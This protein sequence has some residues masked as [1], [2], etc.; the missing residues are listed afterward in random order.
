MKRLFF[1]C[2]LFL[3]G[4]GFAAEGPKLT[5][6]HS[7]WH[8]FDRYDFLLNLGAETIKPM[9]PVTE[10]GDGV[11]DPEPETR[12]CIL[13]VPKKY[14]TGLPWIWR[15]CYWNHEPQTEMELLRRGFCV[16]Y[17]SANHSL[18]PDKAWELWYDFL[19]K[20][21]GLS[22]KP[23]FI[24]MSRGGEYAYLWGVN[25]PECVS[26]IYA[27]NP[28]GNTEIFSK[29]QLLA[30]NDV[31][32]LHVNGSIDPLLGRVSNVIETVYR[33]YGGRIS[34]VIKEGAG[35][36]PHSLKDPKFLADFVEKST[37]E[38]GKPDPV[39][40]VGRATRTAFYSPESDYRKFSSQPEQLV[41]RGA[42]FVNVYDKYDFD[43]PGVEGTVSVVAP[44]SAAEGTPWVFRAGILGPDSLVDL[45]LLDNGFHIA[46]G[47]VPYNA[48]GPQLKDWNKVYEHLVAKG[49]SK[50]PILEGNGAAAMCAYAWA[51]ANPE[52][53]SCIY[54]E[55]PIVQNCTMSDKPIPDSLEP[56]AEAGV[57]VMHFY[58][59]NAPGLAKAEELDQ[60]YSSMPSAN[61]LLGRIEE[62]VSD[63]MTPHSAE[64]IVD[65]LIHVTD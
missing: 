49:F 28:G 58:P 24:G 46:T 45:S 37:R 60:L 1:L 59:R 39:F 27:D 61:R 47:P 35:H 32:L 55:N 62:D 19:V 42:E 63:V 12:R 29:L 54:A 51:A 36:H 44:E 8:G 53:V 23:A 3:T 21:Q 43:L 16:A 52:S 17:I 56:L 4:S 48:D 2:V 7:S 6:P 11:R 13:V 30:K 33:Q 5:H 41:C 9:N 26:C 65:F 34:V 25:H 14:A 10:E 40:T 31:P 18:K 15:G 64:M 50:R 57:P 38:T 22:A 20:E